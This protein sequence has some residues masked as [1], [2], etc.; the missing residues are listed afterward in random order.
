MRVRLHCTEHILTF[1]IFLDMKHPAPFTIWPIYGWIFKYFNGFLRKPPC[2]RA[3]WGKLFY[4]ARRKNKAGFFFLQKAI[5]KLQRR[6]SFTAARQEQRHFWGETDFCKQIPAHL[7]SSPSQF[8]VFSSD[9][10]QK[11][12]VFFPISDFGLVAVCFHLAPG[13]P[14]LP[15]QCLP[16]FWQ[17]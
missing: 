8:L 6:C 11:L 17:G 13:S 4:V 3:F 10:L 5:S 9:F 2:I 14:S 16:L 12:T 1:R 7:S 15:G